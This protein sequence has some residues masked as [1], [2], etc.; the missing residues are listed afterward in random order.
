MNV[1]AVDNSHYSFYPGPHYL[2][3]DDGN[4][5]G[6]FLAVKEVPLSKQKFTKVN[7]IQW[8]K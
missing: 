6:C 5:V 3:D 2:V 1:L 4:I 8:Y 7:N